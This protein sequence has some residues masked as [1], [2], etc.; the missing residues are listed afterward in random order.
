MAH[1]LPAEPKPN[2]K[3]KPN[4]APA[5]PDLTGFHKA[6]GAGGSEPEDPTAAG[7]GRGFAQAG[8]PG[9]PHRLRQD[10]P[11]GTPGCRHWTRQGSGN[12]EGSAGRSDGQQG[13]AG[14]S[15]SNF[16][17]MMLKYCSMLKMAVLP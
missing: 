13:G 6:A 16:I 17:S 2:S 7:S 14:R 15:T 10:G 4:P 12:T 1:A 9:G 8:S 3:P 11:P 5:S